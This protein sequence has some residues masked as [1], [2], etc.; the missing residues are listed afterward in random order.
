M[1]IPFAKATLAAETEPNSGA[2]GVRS[3]STIFRAVPMP[4]KRR[5][6]LLVPGFTLVEMIVALAVI[7]L[8]LAVVA[9]SLILPPRESGMTQALTNARRASVRRG[10]TMTLLVGSDGKWK[11]TAGRYSNGETLLAGK[12]EDSDIF[13]A[14]IVI[15][16]IG[17]CT[18]QRGRFTHAGDRF[19]P[20][21]CSLID[22]D[23]VKR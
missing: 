23:A 21:T 4:A 7:G 20:L 16:P 10:E 18:V 22:H 13:A 19:D 15:S 2:A 11:L 8:A 17:I 12:I 1:E 14:E 6:Y 3:A 9:P 5:T